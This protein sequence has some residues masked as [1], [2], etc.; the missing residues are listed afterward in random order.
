MADP[1]KPR[2]RDKPFKRINNDAFRPTKQ[3]DGDGVA[4]G[5]HTEKDLGT[6]EEIDAKLDDFVAH[7]PLIEL[8]NDTRDQFNTFAQPAAFAI[9]TLLSGGNP[10]AAPAAIIS[11]WK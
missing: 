9:G 6:E 8:I 10:A 3:P 7:T 2:D 4:C 1:T 11:A 5:C